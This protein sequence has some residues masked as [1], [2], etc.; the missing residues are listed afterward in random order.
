M[1][2]CYRGEVRA[3]R[4]EIVA[5]Q[6]EI[7]G[8]YSRF[9]DFS[10]RHIGD[11]DFEAIPR[12]ELMLYCLDEDRRQAGFVRRPGGFAVNGQALVYHHVY[13][14]A[15][16]LISLPYEQFVEL[17][18]TPATKTIA[19]GM[20][21]SG[22]TLVV[23]LLA[24]LPGV[25]ALHEPDGFDALIPRQNRLD[26]E[27]LAL[28]RAIVNALSWGT[29]HLFVVPRDAWGTFRLLS[30]AMPDAAFAFSYREGT[31]HARSVAR[32]YS[33]DPA[34]TD[35]L[36]R[37]RRRASRLH[38]MF[39]EFVTDPVPVESIS[40]LGDLLALRWLQPL[41]CCLDALER[42]IPVCSFRLEEL[43]QHKNG[44][45]A[46]LLEVMDRPDPGPAVWARIRAEF[47]QDAQRGTF[48]SRESL[49][50]RKGN[51][52]QADWDRF[53]ARISDSAVR[54]P[55]FIIPGSVC[56]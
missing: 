28:A 42:K 13:G 50:D 45:V 25:V 22:T 38:T 41:V 46:Q 7:D 16:E 47:D 35:Y 5:R 6:K 18:P 55:G 48:M 56:T 31:A 24:Q 14:H 11:V 12:S 10:T 15:T 39:P 44:A 33:E 54:S 3:T 20:G 8:A 19:L 26:D 29:E 9:A 37:L 49:A 1:G 4:H 43:E 32:M 17:E 2:A 34:S 30:A 40:G 52:S 53:H 21:R 51:A 23:R 36:G 27:T